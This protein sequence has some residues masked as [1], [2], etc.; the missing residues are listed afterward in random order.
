V[1]SLPVQ[2]SLK[3]EACPVPA[4]CVIIV[5]EMSKRTVST[6]FL[7]V[8]LS[9][10]GTTVA[11]QT[12]HVE[13][14][15]SFRPVL[16]EVPDRT[17]AVGSSP[18]VGLIMTPRPSVPEVVPKASPQPKVPPVR[19]QTPKPQKIVT[20]KA[21]TYGPGYD[22]YFALPQGRG[23]KVVICSVVTLRCLTRVS[24]DTGPKK[25]LNRVA[26][27]DVKT[28]EYLCDCNWTKGIQ[29]VTMTFHD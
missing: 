3:R 1:K 12:P 7:A 13:P 5:G 23:H 28:F 19:K 22:G 26:D 24:N 2:N 16:R 11:V 25:S 27:L 20:G 14:V 15:L 10:C 4:N 8:V 9:G 18:A 29:T 21:S 17:P 6:V